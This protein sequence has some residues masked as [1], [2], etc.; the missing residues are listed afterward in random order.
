M[1]VFKYICIYIIYISYIL[2]VRYVCTTQSL[3]KNWAPVAVRASMYRQSRSARDGGKQK[4]KTTTVDVSS[5]EREHSVYRSMRPA[6]IFKSIAI[7]SANS[8]QGR[9]HNC[10]RSHISTARRKEAKQRTHTHIY[11]RLIWTQQSQLC[12][13]WATER[14]TAKATEL[15]FVFCFLPLKKN[16]F[17]SYFLVICLL[18]VLTSYFVSIANNNSPQIRLSL[19]LSFCC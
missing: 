7:R 8:G 6:A 1:D 5:T 13:D 14:Q 15:K 11:Q 16:F 10:R 3:C 2:V 18:L 4:T 19:C 12:G 9:Q 17:V